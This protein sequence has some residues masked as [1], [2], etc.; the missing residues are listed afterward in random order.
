MLHNIVPFGL[1][2]GSPRHDEHHV[3]GNVYYAKFFC[4]LDD[5]FGFIVKDNKNDDKK[6]V[7]SWKF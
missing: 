2:G 5:I 7:D 1:L 6:K 4:Y 3:N